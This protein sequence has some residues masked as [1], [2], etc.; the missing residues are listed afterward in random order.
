MELA[1]AEESQPYRKHEVDDNPDQRGEPM[2]LDGED[3]EHWDR[4]Q[5]GDDRD[6]AG[7][8]KRAGSD[9]V[10]DRHLLELGLGERDLEP[11]QI[12]RLLGDA[13]GE[14]GGRLC[15]THGSYQEMIRPTSIEA[16]AWNVALGGTKELEKNTMTMA[17]TKDLT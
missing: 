4:H 17:E 16:S 7:P 13:R 5:Q 2:R 3:D 9:G 14:V 11:D 1:A 12:L 10:G 6:Q 8:G 15:F